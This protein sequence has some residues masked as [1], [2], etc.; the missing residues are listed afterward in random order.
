MA[1]PMMQKTIWSHVEEYSK[2]F[3]YH[4]VAAS[5]TATSIGIDTSGI[6]AGRNQNL[7][8][9]NEFNSLD[10]NNQQYVNVVH[11]APCIKL[12]KKNAC[13]ANVIHSL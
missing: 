1:S 4:C 11:R 5:G 2:V 10:L 6:G 3:S 7:K 9:S 13:S 12:E 8:V